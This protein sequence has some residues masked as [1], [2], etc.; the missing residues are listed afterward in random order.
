MDCYQQVSLQC[1]TWAEISTRVPPALSGCSRFHGVFLKCWQSR[2]LAPLIPTPSRKEGSGSAPAV[3]L[4]NIKIFEIGVF[5][6]IKI[7]DSH[8]TFI[9]KR[10]LN[11]RNY[12]YGENKTMILVAVDCASALKEHHLVKAAGRSGH[13]SSMDLVVPHVYGQGWSFL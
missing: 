5:S 12:S 2:R 3:V 11:I 13:L 8:Q 9:L 10:E 7:Q 6:R 1:R 4:K